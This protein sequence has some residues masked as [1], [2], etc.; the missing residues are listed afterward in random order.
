[1]WERHRDY[2]ASAHIDL[3][4]AQYQDLVHTAVDLIDASDSNTDPDSQLSDSA[5][6]TTDMSLDS[7][8]SNFTED[9][10]LTLLAS[11]E[12][13]FTGLA[14]NHHHILALEGT[15]IAL[16]DEVEKLCYLTT[17]KRLPHTPQLQLLKEWCL[18]NDL[19]RF[20][21]KLHV[22]PDIF[23][24]LVNRLENHPIFSNNSNNPQFP[25]PV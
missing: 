24:C 9:T 22:D 7:L 17:R 16:A 25:V 13:S 23:A 15:I 4:L 1:M 10:I 5:S 2:L 3:Q 6:S 20:H 18:N 11:S 8:L 21:R 12:S 14:L 19:K